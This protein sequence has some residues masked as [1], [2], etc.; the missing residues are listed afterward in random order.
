MNCEHTKCLQLS[1][2]H[3]K[4]FDQFPREIREFAWRRLYTIQQDGM[5]CFQH[6]IQEKYLSFCEKQFPKI[7]KYQG[8]HLPLSKR[9]E[10]SS[11]IALLKFH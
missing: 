10:L 6:H 8:L 4:I 1:Q 5:Y 11:S 3:K 9:L 7:E 2:T